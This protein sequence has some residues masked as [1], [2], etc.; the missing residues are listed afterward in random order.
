[1]QRRLAHPGHRPVQLHLHPGHR[2]ARRRHLHRRGRQLHPGW[3]LVVEPRLRLRHLG[4][5]QRAPQLHGHLVRPDEQHPSTETTSSVTYGAEGGETISGTV[6]GQTGDGA[7][8]ARSPSPRPPLTLRRS[9]CAATSRS[10]RAPTSPATPAP[11]AP[12]SSTPAPTPTWSP[13]TP[14]LE[15]RRRTPTSP[16]APRT[17]PARPSAHGHLVRPD[18]Q[19]PERQTTSSVTYGAEGGETITGTVT[20]QTGDGAPLGTVTI[21]ATAPDSST[22]TLCSDV[23]L[24]PGTD[25]S[26]YT[27]TLGAAQLDAGTYTDVVASYTPAGTS[28]SNPDFAYGTSDSS[29][30]PLSFTVTSSGQT[31]STQSTETTSSSPTAPRVGDHQ[32]H[33]HRSDRRRRPARHGHHHRDRP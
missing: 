3:N 26:S 24:T 22:I 17:R 19:H 15:P 16:T 18:E 4:L 28:S 2:P 8:S 13:A 27:C 25:Q 20:G 33:R 11:W 21:T 32:R 29:S 9:P 5:V 6:T 23:S 14:R 30:A 12:P 1:M 7:R 31:S 10:P